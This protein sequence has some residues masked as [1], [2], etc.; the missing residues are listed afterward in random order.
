MSSKISKK[1]IIKEIIRC[2]RDPHYFLNNYAKV[3]HPDKGLLPFKIFDYQGDLVDAF[4][5]HRMNLI[6]KARQLGITTVVGGYIAW[7]ILFH[8]DKNALVVAT[9]QETAKNTVRV[10]KTIFKYL[11]NWM[12]SVGRIE[13]N[14]RN[15]VE[16][17]NGSRV[18]AVT[19]TS[20]VGRSEALSLLFV[21]ALL[22]IR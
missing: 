19:T 21:D 15:G 2:G 8:R 9:K 13:I 17:S 10:V 7:L 4:I 14:N 6:L 11:P 5:Q 16:L 1:E 22:K 18:K 20:D 12:M 3:Q